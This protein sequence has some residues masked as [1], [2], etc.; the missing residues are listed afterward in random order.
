M[1]RGFADAWQ[2]PQAGSRGKKAETKP[3]QRKV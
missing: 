3:L 2:Y 1:T